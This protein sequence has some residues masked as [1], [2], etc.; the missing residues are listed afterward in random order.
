M[1]VGK[2]KA[3]SIA[4]EGLRFIL[5]EE[6]TCYDRGIRDQHGLSGG[7]LSSDAV[8]APEGVF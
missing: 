2:A 6:N 8:T 5:A 4:T 7:F 3:P 1:Y